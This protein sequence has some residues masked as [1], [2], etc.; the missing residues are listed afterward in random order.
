MGT[1]LEK[2][3]RD[4]KSYDQTFS[5]FDSPIVDMKDEIEE[6]PVSVDPSKSKVRTAEMIE[7]VM[8]FAGIDN[9]DKLLKIATKEDFSNL[10]GDTPSTSIN[11]QEIYNI[12]NLFSK[13]NISD[14]MKRMVNKYKE[15]TIGMVAQDNTGEFIEIDEDLYYAILHS[16]NKETSDTNISDLKMLSNFTKDGFKEKQFK[17]FGVLPYYL[18]QLI[19]RMGE[20][21]LGKKIPFNGEEMYIGEKVYL[22]A[23]QA[24]NFLKS[25]YKSLDDAIRILTSMNASEED[26][27][28]ARR[29]SVLQEYIRAVESVVMEGIMKFAGIDNIENLL[30]MQPVIKKIEPIADSIELIEERHLDEPHEHAKEEKIV[31]LPS[32]DIY[33]GKGI[34]DQDPSG[35]GR[36]I[37]L[38][39]SFNGI[40]N[41]E[42]LLKKSDINPHTLNSEQPTADIAYKAEEDHD[43]IDDQHLGNRMSYTNLDDMIRAAYWAETVQTCTKIALE[44]GP[45]Q[46]LR[47]KLLAY[48]EKDE[49]KYRG[50][51]KKYKGELE[52]LKEMK[53]QLLNG[54]SLEEVNRGL[55]EPV[56]EDNIDEREQRLQDAELNE[57]SEQD[58]YNNMLWHK[59]KENVA[60]GGQ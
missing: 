30:K 49:Q 58:A 17:N 5:D 22:A 59:N 47:N 46:E 38:I 55:V 24:I 35:A 7:N 37:N 2:Y 39:A 44:V 25:R 45:E 42:E 57:I 40:T 26:I 31:V 23:Q 32:Q 27:N 18:L 48:L 11:E 43:V 34:L 51:L 12:N 16:I 33:N 36:N 53:R 15:N 21:V 1:I 13:D 56:F 14:D 50:K 9:V 60:M 3:M 28:N 4:R 19:D 54:A 52:R 20:K 10:F 41:I 6:L 29:S 8:H